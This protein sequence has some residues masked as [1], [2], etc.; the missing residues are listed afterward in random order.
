MAMN[1]RGRFVTIDFN[2]F[3]RH[4][5]ARMIIR[6]RPSFSCRTPAT[7]RQGVLFGKGSSV[8]TGH[9]RSHHRNPHHRWLSPRRRAARPERIRNADVSVSLVPWKYPRLE[10]QQKQ[11]HAGKAQGAQHHI[12]SAA[13]VVIISPGSSNPQVRAV[14]SQPTGR[15]EILSSSLPP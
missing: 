10:T 8:S 4:H 13:A 6:P 3:H 15:R 5:D 1:D 9:I 11:R 2:P 14:G 12:S 7:T